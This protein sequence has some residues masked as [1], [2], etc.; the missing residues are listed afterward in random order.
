VTRRATDPQARRA[1]EWEDR[2]LAPIQR[3]VVTLSGAQSVVDGIFLGNGWRWP[4][5]VRAIAKQATTKAG[6]ANR[7]FIW[8]HER[9]PDWVLCHEVAHS[10]TGIV[11]GGSDGHG[12]DWLGLYIKLLAQVCEMPVPMLLF[13]LKDAGLT[14]NLGAS[15]WF[16][17]PAQ[18]RVCEVNVAHVRRS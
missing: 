9:T 17:S 2:W 13:T 12:P 11:E 16:L 10:L 4:P 8:L 15:P 5:K 18:S 7:Q 1:Y 14:W 6:Q 3:R